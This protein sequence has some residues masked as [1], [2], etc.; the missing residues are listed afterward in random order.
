MV[1]RLVPLSSCIF[2][3]IRHTQCT[4]VRVHIVPS[5]KGYEKFCVI[6]WLKDEPCVN[7]QCLEKLL[8]QNTA[9][10]FSSNPCVAQQ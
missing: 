9:V 4:N 1:I 3:V 10:T 7:L 6:S 5:K 8:E 2:V